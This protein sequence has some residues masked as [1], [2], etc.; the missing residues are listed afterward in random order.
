MSE[1]DPYDISKIE[2]KMEE[3]KTAAT[4]EENV[5]SM[6]LVRVVMIGN[7]NWELWVKC[8]CH[9]C[10]ICKLTFQRAYGQRNC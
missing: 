3:E 1:V 6:A 7:G 9:N 10:I 8:E 2:A 5:L 4:T